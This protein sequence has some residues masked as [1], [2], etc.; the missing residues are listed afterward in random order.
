MGNAPPILLIL[1]YGII[2]KMCGVR[3]AGPLS[4]VRS[5]GIDIRVQIYA[6]EL[7]HK[8]SKHALNTDMNAC[9]IKRMQ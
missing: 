2:T 1:Q 9:S 5:E 8:M 3:A 4:K 6:D 7:L